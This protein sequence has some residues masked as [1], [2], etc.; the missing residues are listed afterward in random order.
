MLTIYIKSIKYLLNCCR[1]VTPPS[2]VYGT[3]ENEASVMCME[4]NINFTFHVSAFL[5]YSVILGLKSN[6]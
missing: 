1:F 2:F 3:N 5:C 6:V 4:E